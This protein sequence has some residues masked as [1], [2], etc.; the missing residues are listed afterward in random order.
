MESEGLAVLLSVKI[1]RKKKHQQQRGCDEFLIR[2]IFNLWK[3]LSSGDYG[4]DLQYKVQNTMTIVPLNESLLK[5]F[6]PFYLITNA[7]RE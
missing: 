3:S 1:T 7:L 2:A 6:K 5:L 4:C